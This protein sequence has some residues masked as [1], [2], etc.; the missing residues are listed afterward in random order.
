M[1]YPHQHKHLLVCNNLS[2]TTFNCQ[3]RKIILPRISDCFQHMHRSQVVTLPLLLC[4][5]HQQT[6]TCINKYALLPLLPRKILVSPRRP[7][8]CLH[9]LARALACNH[10][11]HLQGDKL[12]LI[13]AQVTFDLL[14]VFQEG[15]GLEN[16]NEEMTINIVNDNNSWTLVQR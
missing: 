10:H 2:L 5:L 1:F 3:N 16:E 7:L 4:F 11:T 9:T 15:E 12:Q 8:L 6:H 13:F 14:P